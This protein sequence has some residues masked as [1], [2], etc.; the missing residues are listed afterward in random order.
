MANL[1]AYA[2]RRRPSPVTLEG[3][4]CRL[5][6]LDVASH[7]ESLHAASMA[8]G[9]EQRFRYLFEAPQ[10]LAEFRK[11]VE[12]AA[13][14]V[15]PLYFA[16]VDLRTDRCEGRQAFMRIVPEHGVL[17]LG[18]TLWGPAIAHGYR[19]WLASDNFSPDGTQHRRLSECLGHL[20]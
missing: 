18:S 15:D 17:E 1:T 13:S 7:G 5:V 14:S 20:L 9:S 19:S 3:A 4:Y 2:P 6:P 16:V 12:R 11:W 10:P 8:P